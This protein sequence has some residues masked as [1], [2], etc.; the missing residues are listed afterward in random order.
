LARELIDL[1]AAWAGDRTLYV[2]ADS[3]YAGRELLRARPL[4]VHVISRLRLDAA[5]WTR[6]RRRCPGQKGRPRRRGTRVPTPQVLAATWRRW[7]PLPLTLYGRTITPRVFAL[8]ALWYAALPDH[9]IRIVVVRDP[10]GRR[11][12]EAFFCTDTAAP[13]AFVLEGYARRWTLEVTFHDTKQ[14]LGLADSQAQSPTAVR[15]TAPFALF[16]YA[17]VLLWYAEA[18]HGATPVDWPARPWYPDKATASC[19]DMLTTLRRAGWRRYLSAAPSPSRRPRNP[20]FSWPEAV[21][22]TA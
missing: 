11:Q 10:T 5:L 9:P 1:V 21:L 19:S 18:A 22:A 15:R 17:L 8:T 20:A 4:N 12:D 2:V 16:V 14:S 3:A 13:E 7:R 6:P